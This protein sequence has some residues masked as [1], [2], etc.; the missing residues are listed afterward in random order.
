MDTTAFEQD[1]LQLFREGGFAGESRWLDDPATGG[2]TY[3]I[4]RGEGAC[5]TVLVHGGIAE[6]SVWYRLAPHL[7]GPVVIL[8]S[9][10]SL[11][12]SLDRDEDLELGRLTSTRGAQTYSVPILD[13]GRRVAWVFCKPYGVEVARA[14]LTEVQ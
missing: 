12:R 2:R 7:P 14:V 10:E 6:A 8:S 4:T 3:A 1:R 11:G 5:P 13:D 9:R